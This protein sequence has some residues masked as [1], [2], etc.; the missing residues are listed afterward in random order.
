VSDLFFLA[1]I[2][3][4]FLLAALFVRGCDR[5]I[6]ADETAPAAATAVDDAGEQ[7]AA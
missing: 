6:G 5:I 3:T 7:V 2:L 4:F 1:I